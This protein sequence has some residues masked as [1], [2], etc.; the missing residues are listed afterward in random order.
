MIFKKI[1]K[2]ADWLYEIKANTHLI[3]QELSKD[4]ALKKDIDSLKLQ[5]A[6]LK[7]EA[8]KSKG[9]VDSLHEVE[10][11]AFSQFGDDGI[12]QYLIH[13]VDISSQ[14]FIEFGV[15][16]Y[17]EANTRLLLL[18]NN[19]RGLIIDG[20]EHHINHVKR[21]DVYWRHDLTAV[22]QFI[23]KENINHI[24]KNNRFVGEVGLLSIDIDGNDYWVWQAIDV[25]NPTIVIVEYN[26]VLGDEHAVTIPY[27]ADFYRTDAHYSNLYWGASLQALCMLAEEKGYYFVGC[28]SAGNN[29]YFIRKDKIGDLK[30][31]TA[32][33]G[34]VESKF[35][36]SRHENYCLSFISG[37]DRLKV[38]EDCEVYDVIN[39]RIIK[40]KDLD[41]A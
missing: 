13:H 8:I 14:T 26:S 21:S 11:K 36:E 33:Q 20:S 17:E 32:K 4:R 35:R 19:W 39:H 18:N 3:M 23:D 37:K 29:A 16:N 6:N 12:I 15:E 30:P 28:N 24:F 2:L 10:F 38:I 31:L 1:K 40:I 41:K 5:I 25:V 22:A 27:K 9:L 7:I 34:Y